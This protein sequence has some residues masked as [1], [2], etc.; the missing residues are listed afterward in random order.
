MKLIILS[1]KFILYSYKEILNYIKNRTFI[2]RSFNSQVPNGNYC[3][4]AFGFKR[5]CAYSLNC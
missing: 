2:I 3:R 4:D 5:M 1:N